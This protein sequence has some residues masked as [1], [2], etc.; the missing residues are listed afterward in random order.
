MIK[1]NFF[2]IGAILLALIPLL[3]MDVPK[4]YID[5]TREVHDE[6]IEV[7]HGNYSYSKTQKTTLLDNILNSN[8]TLMA[9]MY[10]KSFLSLI[11]LVS[12]IYFF[13]RYSKQKETSF[14]KASLITITLTGCV[15]ALKVFT[16]INFQGNSAVKLLNLSAQD[17]TLSAIYNSN[18][19]GKVLYVD[20]WGTTCG[21]CLEEFRNFTKPLKSK[22]H[23]R[24]NIA[25]LYICQ[26]YELIWKQQLKKYNIEGSHLF[27]ESSQY[28]QLFKNSIKGSKN[29]LIAMPRYLIIDKMG[30]IVNTDA[31]RPSN[32]D[33]LTSQLNK[34]L[35][36]NKKSL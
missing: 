30:T 16:W 11:L 35:V 14:W 29:T 28:N 36:V 13:S 22:Y 25:Y 33:S 21:P 9:Y 32:V 8:Q 1:S 26:G 34:Y 12:S 2:W 23:N 17:T 7:V 5:W 4:H 19:K 31:P 10:I 3:I 20:F 24:E 27:L 6:I 18:F 15:V